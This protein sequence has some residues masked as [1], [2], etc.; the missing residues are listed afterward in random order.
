M[1]PLLILAV[2]FVVYSFFVIITIETFTQRKE[3]NN[4]FTVPSFFFFYTILISYVINFVDISGTDFEKIIQ[5]G[6]FAVGGG[7]VVLL[8]FKD[9]IKLEQDKR[10]TVSY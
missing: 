2:L 4:Q 7:L 5:T 9:R 1:I 6:I 8:Y 10:T 3:I